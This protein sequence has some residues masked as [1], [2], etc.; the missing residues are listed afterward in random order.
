M[1]QPGCRLPHDTGLI[2][3]VFFPRS[4]R[5][6]VLDP[7]NPANNV[8]ITSRDGSTSKDAEGW[9]TV[10]DVAKTTLGRQPLKDIIVNEKWK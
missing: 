3:V 4:F 10:A 2:N 6:F 7:A 1:Y 9:K 5:P 8:C